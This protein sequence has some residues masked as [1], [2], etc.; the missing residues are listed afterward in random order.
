MICI[1][2][3]KLT[4]SRYLSAFGSVNKLRF[5]IFK[6]VIRRNSILFPYMT[7]CSTKEIL[8]RFG[9]TSC[10][11][12]ER[13]ASI[14]RDILSKFSSNFYQTTRCY[15][16]HKLGSDSGINYHSLEK[17]DKKKF[18]YKFVQSPPSSADVKNQRS[19]T[20]LPLVAS[21]HAQGQ[22]YFVLLQIWTGIA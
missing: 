3:Y 15:I 12:E 7:P 1:L 22:V 20:F 16:S 17:I 11:T 18:V 13:V 9:K 19:C 4:R 14:F 5:E 10:S 2:K 21:Q 6:A 8:R